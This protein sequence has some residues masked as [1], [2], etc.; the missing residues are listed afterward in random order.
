MTMRHAYILF[1]TLILAN[2]VMAVQL[3]EPFVKEVSNG[4]TIDLGEIGPGQ[5]IS[6]ALYP[7][8][9][10]GGT[11]GQGGRYDLAAVTKVPQGWSSKDS[12]LYGDPLQV[13][14]TAD[15]NAPD[16]RY[17]ARVIVEDENGAENI[18]D[19]AFT[20]A[21]TINHDV[22]DAQVDPPSLVVGPGQPARYAITITNKGRASD[23]FVVRA[24]GV[25]RWLFEKPVHVPAMSS[26]TVVYEITENEEARYF[27]IINVTSSSSPDLIHKEQKISFKVESDLFHDF[28][29]ANNGIFVFPILEA[30]AYALAGLI[31]NLW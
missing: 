29:A 9:T 3:I 17:T 2:A 6:L 24:V 21:I 26:K 1:L 30:P 13:E 23:V 31:S 25:E 27:P 19:V 11:F 4:D 14:I 7:K 10:T 28:K 5:T 12:N 15:R 22:L 20:V 8:V 16:G 18:G